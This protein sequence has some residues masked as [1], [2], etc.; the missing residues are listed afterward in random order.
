MP[1][2]KRD[3]LNT[4][5]HN[6]DKIEDAID[7]DEDGVDESDIFAGAKDNEDEDNGDRQDTAL[8]DI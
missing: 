1:Q 2:N 8:A 3:K 6:S 5:D 4:M 7:K